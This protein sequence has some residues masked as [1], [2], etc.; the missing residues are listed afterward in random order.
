MLSAA[1]RLFVALD[2][3]SAHAAEPVVKQL[4]SEV[5]GFKVGAEL[6]YSHGP[7]IS[8]LIVGL[9]AQLFLDLKLHDIPRTVEA[10]AKRLAKQ[11]AAL[12][13]VHAS[14]GSE[15]VRAAVEGAS[16]N[17]R[18]RVLAVTV[19]TSHTQETLREVGVE[20]TLPAQV[21]ALAELA[22]R[23]GAHGLV[24]SAQEAAVLREALGAQVTLLC[25]GIRPLG[26]DAGD[27]KRVATPFDALRAGADLLVV[28]RPILE[29]SDRR[30]AT[31]A[32]VAD[33]VRALG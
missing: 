33:M 19:L 21:L 31:A 26:S 6:Y 12:I 18:T 4:A 5:G 10:G 29:A 2:L 7:A 23:S 8:D 13:T 22:V 32:I 25:P 9:G 27:Q 24:C 3:P 14:G 30:A 20:R 28:G 11:G 15:V 1:Q 17:S 16:V